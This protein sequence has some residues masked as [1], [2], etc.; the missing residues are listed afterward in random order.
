MKLQ[1]LKES[2]NVLNEKTFKSEKE[3]NLANLGYRNEVK[4]YIKDAFVKP[5]A[6]KGYYAV[7]D[8][9]EV[10]KIGFQKKSKICDTIYLNDTSEINFSGANL[11]ELDQALQEWCQELIDTTFKQVKEKFAF[12]QVSEAVINEYGPI[13]FVKN[14][15]KNLAAKVAKV[16]DKVSTN[17]KERND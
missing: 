16:A 4:K 10:L 1:F 7:L 2:K 5:F 3:N 9:D 13:N 8:K 17:R 15:A 14:L 12:K 11:N 6:E